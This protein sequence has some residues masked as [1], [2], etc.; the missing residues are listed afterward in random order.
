[1]AVDCGDGRNDPKAKNPAKRNRTVVVSAFSSYKKRMQTI[2]ATFK[3][4]F[5]YK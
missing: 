4:Y 1:M 3:L 2:A 5:R